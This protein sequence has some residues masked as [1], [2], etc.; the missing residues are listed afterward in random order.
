MVVCID[1]NTAAAG[2]NSRFSAFIRHWWCAL[3]CIESNP[4]S[5]GCLADM[6]PFAES[7]KTYRHL[8]WHDVLRLYIASAVLAEPLLFSDDNFSDKAGTR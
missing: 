2:L 8:T 6:S 3:E 7:G 1:D 4:P 5:D